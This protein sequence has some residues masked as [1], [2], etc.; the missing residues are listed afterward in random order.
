MNRFTNRRVTVALPDST[1]NDLFSKESW[2]RLERCGD[3]RISPSGGTL[4]D[5]RAADV[6][7]DTDVLV[8]GWGTTTH[9]RRL[10]RLAPRLAAL[11]HTAGSVRTLVDDADLA[12]GLVV[13]SQADGNARPVAE[14]TLAMILLSGKAVFPVQHAYRTHRAPREASELL[15]G[16]GLYGLRVGIIGASRVGRQVLGLLSPFD[17]EI[18]LHD[19]L[20]SAAEAERLGARSVSLDELMM[21]CPV[22]SLHAPLLD[23]TRGMITARHLG[24]LPD[25]ATFINTAR[26]ALVDQHALVAELATGRIQA[27]LDVTEPEVPEATSPLWDLPNVV[28]TP[29]CAGSVGNEVR[30]LGDGAV[31]EVERLAHGLPLAHAI[32]RDRFSRTA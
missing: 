7:A 11:V 21:L 18:L 22:V 17:V 12:D 30:R 14:Y 2:E 23:T 3:V 1:L 24:L 32:G 15:R 20:T 27:V 28:L 9:G 31:R 16:R 13:S 4:T 6:L 5:P 26:G 25:G 10:R 29:H 8:T 19:P